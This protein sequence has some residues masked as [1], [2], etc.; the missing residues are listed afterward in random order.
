[1]CAG[2]QFAFTNLISFTSARTLSTSYGYSPLKIGFVILSFG[3]GT[4]LLFSRLFKQTDYH[5]LHSVI[6]EASLVV[7]GVAAGLIMSLHVSKRQMMV[8]VIQ[9]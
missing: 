2:L 5:F 4:F 3:I 6:Q 7:W 8:K 9:R 1:V